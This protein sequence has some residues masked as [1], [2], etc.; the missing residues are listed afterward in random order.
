MAL[1]LASWADPC[2]VFPDTPEEEKN[3]IVL[4][5]VLPS[6]AAKLTS[7]VYTGKDGAAKIATTTRLQFSLNFA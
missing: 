5:R 7:S 3:G 1:S 2:Y 6:L 4:S